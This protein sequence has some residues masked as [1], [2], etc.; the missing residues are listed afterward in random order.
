[1]QLPP[2]PIYAYA[3]A[4][5][6][7]ASLLALLSLVGDGC[8]DLS[9]LDGGGGGGAAVVPTATAQEAIRGQAE[10][11]LD[12]GRY[13]MAW[14][15]EVDAGGDRARLEAVA[16]AALEGRSRHVGDMF[17]ALRTKH[18]ALA[19]GPRGRVD[20]LVAAARDAGRWSRALEM[21][22]FT[23]D[24]P[25]NFSRAWAVYRQVPAEQSAALLPLLQDA[26]A[27]AEGK[28]D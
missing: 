19:A 1:M 7:R 26:Q 4:M 11:A 10:K 28:G 20:G 12:E 15:L 14:N 21:E 9:A 23:A 13:K 27:A 18:G 24:D 22:L 2:S 3:R 5:L 25:G 6:L 8:S 17:A 16:L